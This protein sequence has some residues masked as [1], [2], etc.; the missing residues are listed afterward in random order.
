MPKMV[1][2]RPSVVLYGP[3]LQFRKPKPG[4]QAAASQSLSLFIIP[5]RLWSFPVNFCLLTLHLVIPA[6]EALYKAW[7][8]QAEADDRPRFQPFSPALYV[9]CAKI[10]EYYEKTTESPAYIMSMS[11]NPFPYPKHD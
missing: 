8:N 9:A 10:D 4:R 1:S 2:R 3:G 11:M 7:S 6:L 5:H